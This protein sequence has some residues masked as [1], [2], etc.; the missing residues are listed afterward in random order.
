MI[1]TCTCIYNSLYDKVVM[2]L[3]ILD[4]REFSTDDSKQR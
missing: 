3:F 4:I 2:V 1:T